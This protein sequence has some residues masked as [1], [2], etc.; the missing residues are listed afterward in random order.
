MRF[1]CQAQALLA[2]LSVVTRAL[3][4]RTTQSILEGV[5][6]RATDEGIE[7]TCSDGTISIVTTVD[8]TVTEEGCVVL[9]GKLFLDVVRKMP[10]AQMDVVV[11]D[12]CSCTMKCLGVRMTLA[13]Q[14]GKLFPALPLV[15]AENS[16]TLP[17]AV[18]R[19]MMTQTSFAIAVEDPRKV[20]NGCLFEI[21]KGEATMVALDGFRLALR[22]TRLSGDAPDLS[23]IIP[24]KTVNE[25]AKILET[26]EEKIAMILIG[27]SQMMI[28]L[29]QTIFYSTL[30][31]GEYINYRQILP[32]DWTTRVKIDRDELAM[33]VDRASL[34]AREGRNNLVKMEV[35]NGML[36]ITSNS[37]SGNVYEELEVE[38]EGEN[39]VIAFN[40]QFV[41]DI[42]RVMP[43]G[44]AYMQFKSAVS[45]CLI[46]PEQGD[47]FVYLMLPVRVNA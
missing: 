29:G 13:G 25:I 36:I 24:G 5:M 7:L 32:S 17:Q 10:Q 12:A 39:M 44:E 20:L 18:L 8:A 4:P 23:A 16:F 46:A 6:I 34:I 45:P 33:C 42:L 19:E 3:S 14:P 2:G 35:Q 15:S 47:E 30:I 41:A 31:D 1:L 11:N 21:K 37:E 9:P 38:T 40:V 26:N 22:K 43:E 27:G 28:N